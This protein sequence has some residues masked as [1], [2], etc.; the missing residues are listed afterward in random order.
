MEDFNLSLKINQITEEEKL[1]KETYKLT[2]KQRKQEVQNELKK[3]NLDLE[4]LQYLL[5]YY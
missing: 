5:C 2:L 3:E 1:I 4:K